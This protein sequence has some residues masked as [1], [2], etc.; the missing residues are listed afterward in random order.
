MEIG[1]RTQKSN[2]KALRGLPSPRAARIGSIFGWL[3][4]GLKYI[5][6]IGGLF[7]L[8]PLGI[9]ELM[10]GKREPDGPAFMQ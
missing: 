1:Q 9:I 10:C 3:I 7:M 4:V 5:A 2:Q 6:W 8:I